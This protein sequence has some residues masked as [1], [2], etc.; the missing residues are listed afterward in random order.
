M[1]KTIYLAGG[2]FW[3]LQKLMSELKG[4]VYTT[5]GYANGSGEGDAKYQKVCSGR[6]GFRE[7]VRVDYDP[8]AVDLATLLHVFFYVIDPEA[9]NRQGNDVGS[10]YQSGIYYDA[11]DK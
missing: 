11:Q 6:T 5:A 9:V 7:T 1:I 4:V 8:A 2:C 10:Q 3:G